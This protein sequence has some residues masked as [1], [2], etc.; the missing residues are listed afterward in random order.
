MVIESI[1]TGCVRGDGGVAVVAMVV[2]VERVHPDG[3]GGARRREW[4]WAG[5]TR[6]GV[7]AERPSLPRELLVPSP[8]RNGMPGDSW[9]EVPASSA[10]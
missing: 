3:G 1:F 8:R 5:F 9:G 7:D 2:V 6:R 10:Q 4:S